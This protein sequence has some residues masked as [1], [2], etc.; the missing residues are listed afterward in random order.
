MFDICIFCIDLQNYCLPFVI[1]A[2][3]L[4]SR[5]CLFYVRCTF[6][7][8]LAGSLQH[9][10]GMSIEGGV[11]VGGGRGVGSSKHNGYLCAWELGS[12]SF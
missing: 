9:V 8:Q 4:E 2:I 11:V 5:S 1:S 6:Q 10:G 7:G 12:F 3:Q